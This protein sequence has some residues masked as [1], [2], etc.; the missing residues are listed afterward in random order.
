ME[1]WVQS[2]I[3]HARVVHV[4]DPKTAKVEAGRMEIQDDSQLCSEFK[5]NLEFMRPCQNQEERKEGRTEG[6]F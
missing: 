6:N 2:Q 5:A 4:C 3:L 1:P